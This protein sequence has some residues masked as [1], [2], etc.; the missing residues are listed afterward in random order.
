MKAIGDFF[1]NMATGATKM[2]GGASL[3][4]KRAFN[5][6]HSQDYDAM[7]NLC[8][9]M[10]PKQ[11]INEVKSDNINILHHCAV[12]DNYDALA[13]LAALPYFAEVINDNSNEA[14]WTPLLTACAQSNKT[15][16]RLIKLMV[17]NG[18]DLLKQKK[19]DG[20]SSVHFAASN[21]DVHLLDYIF[22]QA[23]NAKSV[24]NI[25][26]NEGWTPSHFAGFLNNFDSL[27]L[28]IEQGADLTSRNKNGL[29]CFDEIV[30]S[31]N[32]ELFECIWPFAKKVKRDLNERATFGFLHLAAGQ[33]GSKTLDVLLSKCKE[34]PNQICNYH[35]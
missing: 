4:G 12:E 21:N 27:N 5:A 8:A 25:E 29:S 3:R 24:S 19:G 11:F 1:R 16:L 17:E 23:E 32:S 31:D 22:S 33:E 6:Y 20:L 26:S 13:A 30:R 28:L 34:S 14:G 10:K 7:V 18:A 9:T 2:T 35:D 15:D